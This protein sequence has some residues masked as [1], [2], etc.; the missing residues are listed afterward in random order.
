M[1]V[2]VA[3]IKRQRPVERDHGFVVPAEHGLAS[4]KIA[5]DAGV[6]GREIDRLGVVRKRIGVPVLKSQRV[7]ARIVGQ[8]IARVL[9]NRL[10]EQRDGALKIA[11]VQ[12]VTAPVAIAAYSMDKIPDQ[13]RDPDKQCKDNETIHAANV[14]PCRSEKMMCRHDNTLSPQARS[15]INSQ[16]TF[17]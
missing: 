17:G 11:F 5:D 16:M 9:G 4:P 1:V 2:G 15:S 14:V 8:R 10:R 3:R 7:T 6:M 13:N 12:M